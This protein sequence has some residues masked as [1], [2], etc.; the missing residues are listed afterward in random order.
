[1]QEIKFRAWVFAGID[2]DAEPFMEEISRIN[3]EEGTVHWTRWEEDSII[4]KECI[5]M[6]YIRLKDE[7][8]T[9]YCKGDIAKLLDGTIYHIKSFEDVWYDIGHSDGT[10]EDELKNGEVIGNIFENK[11]LLDV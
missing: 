10:I 2:D 8:G 11:E 5:L 7:N 4:E 6:Q 9:N 1:M 3:L